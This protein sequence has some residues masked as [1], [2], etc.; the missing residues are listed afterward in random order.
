MKGLAGPDVKKNKYCIIAK[1]T[2]AAGCPTNTTRCL[3]CVQ[4]HGAHASALKHAGCTDA[5]VTKY[6]DDMGKKQGG[7]NGNGHGHGNGGGSGS[8]SAADSEQ[9]MY[10]DGP[11]FR[12]DALCFCDA[13]YTGTDCSKHSTATAEHEHESSDDAVVYHDITD[14]SSDKNGFPIAAPTAVICPD[15][16]SSCPAGSSCASISTGG[17]GCCA[18]ADAVMC[19]CGYCCPKDYV[20][21][22]TGGVGSATHCEKH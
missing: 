7:S 15:G 6:C 9:L 14:S 21:N 13:G 4:P 1:C 5:M 20:C 10:Y 22:T 18:A 16:R 8:G 19:D 17:W 2:V 3:E 12:D 11:L